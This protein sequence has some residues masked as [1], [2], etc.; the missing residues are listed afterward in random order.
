MIKLKSLLKEGKISISELNPND[1][2]LI[3]QLETIIGGKLNT[4]YTGGSGD[5]RFVASIKISPGYSEYEITPDIMRK[6]LKFNIKYIT[7][8]TDIINVAFN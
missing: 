8:G 4:I 2:K 1:Q 5:G 7:G 3:K 6:L